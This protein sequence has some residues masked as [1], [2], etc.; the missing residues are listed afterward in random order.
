M[1][2]LSID[3][4]FAMLRD[5]QFEVKVSFIEIYNERVYD[6]LSENSQES[7]YSKGAK[8]SGSTKVSINNSDEAEKI[9]QLGNKNRHVRAT[10]L[11]VAS[12]RS[13]AMFSIFLTILTTDGETSS[14]MH[15]CDL[16]GSEGLR[17]T[18]HTG[19][20]QKESVNINQGLLAVGKVVQA[21]SSGKKLVP[22]RDSVLTTVL[23]DSLNI[24][25]YLTI[26]G[27]ISPAEKDKNETMSTV[28]FAQSVK[29]LD[30]KSLPE[31]N[32]YL[33]EKKVSR[34]SFLFVSFLTVRSATRAG[35]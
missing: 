31:F 33:N 12:S 2:S 14:L 13:H 16:A 6:L 15:I 5:E 11:N 17:N 23:Q 4:I 32:S 3:S 35:A 34:K 9:L 8:F 22:Y 29:T 1:I 26:L 21:L 28:R 30:S 10:K 25:S 7:I 24:N 19:I 20:A 18:N 27:C